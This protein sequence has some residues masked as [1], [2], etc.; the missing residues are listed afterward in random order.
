[1]PTF[2]E[3]FAG[4]GMAR[5]GLG[6]AWTCLF[7]NDFD[8]KKAA[9]YQRNWGA[10][11]FVAGDIAGLGADDIPGHVDLAWAS[12]PCQDLSVAGDGAG[13]AGGRSGFFWT[14]WDLMTD[15]RRQGRAPRLIVLENVCGALSARGAQD[16]AAIA[17]TCVRA[18]HRFGA[19]VMDAAL[20]VPQSRPR[21]FMIAARADLK[22]PQG[23]GAGAPSPQWHPPTL[24]AAYEK[25]SP[26]AKRNW[27]WWSFAQP[28]R[29]NTGLADLIE[30]RPAGVTW[31]TPPET[32][33]L[34]A[35][36]NETNRAK[37]RQA[38]SLAR[39]TIGTVYRRTRRDKSGA[40]AQRAEIRFDNVAGC[41]RTPA[42]GSSRQLI[43]VV[44]GENVRSRLISARE[45]ARLM[46][47]PDE[48][49]L[50]ENYNEAYHLTGDGVAVPVV[51]HLS[52][53]VL[54]PILA[55]NSA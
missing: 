24:C 10:A 43:M 19:V 31:H 42:G 47:L 4:G 46:G 50:P 27:I 45:T 51:R 26:A 11:E 29:R 12:F 1:M 33:R 35:L 6:D 22:L 55:A 13:L 2:H 53:H 44:E 39:R 54:E 17:E 7:A 38:Q 16:F 36:M 48:Y 5:A 25:L 40:R 52:A 49:Q 9:A 32:E 23:M 18:G 20:F 8:E 30:D 21:L 34:L 28:A 37:V 15:L 41:L 3:F 14:F